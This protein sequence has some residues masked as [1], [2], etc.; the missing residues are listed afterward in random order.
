MNT[1]DIQNMSLDELIMALSDL[2]Y[3]R[4]EDPDACT[5]YE[6]VDELEARC[7]GSEELIAVK[8]ATKLQ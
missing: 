5:L 8:A 6:I 7:A 1:L 2:V 4:V 3:G